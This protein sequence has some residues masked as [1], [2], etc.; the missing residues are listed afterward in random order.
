MVNAN[1]IFNRVMNQINN[2]IL[3][4]EILKSP[5]LSVKLLSACII[6]EALRNSLDEEVSK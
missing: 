4:D 5:D 1:S 3:K 2:P 6:A